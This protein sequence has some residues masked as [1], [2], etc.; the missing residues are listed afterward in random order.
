LTSEA[1]YAAAFASTAGG[2]Q[3]RVAQNSVLIY[4]RC[5]LASTKG[6]IRARSKSTPAR[7]YIARLSIFNL[8]IWPSTC[9]LSGMMALA[10]E[11]PADLS[12]DRRYGETIRDM[13]C[14]EHASAGR[15]SVRAWAESPSHYLVAPAARPDA[16]RARI[17]SCRVA[18]ELPKGQPAGK[19]AEGESGR[20][21]YSSRL[22]GGG[23]A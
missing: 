19:E 1:S 12:L 18:R 2:C 8:L 11:C 21:G 22:C 14:R 20:I 23:D 13:G 10:L 7:P 3:C 17:R 5:K 6:N 4:S 16:L 9:P 15:P